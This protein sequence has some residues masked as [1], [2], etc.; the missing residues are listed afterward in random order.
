MF[1]D[2]MQG[3]AQK[4][5]ARDV[6]ALIDGLRK[7]PD[8]DVGVILAIATAVRVNMETH[9]VIPEG[10]FQR[11]S[12]PSVREMGVM[13]MRINRTA[14]DFARAKLQADATGA[15]IWSYSLRCLNVPGLRPL[16]REMWAELRRGFPHV[17][18]AIDESEERNGKPFDPRVRAEW[19]LIPLGLAPDGPPDG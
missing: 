15:T 2:W 16:G 5:A 17:E 7:L 14:V 13:Q 4:S 11:N 10:I 9:D 1:K 6:Q 12:L 8:R 18:E 3:R 19:R